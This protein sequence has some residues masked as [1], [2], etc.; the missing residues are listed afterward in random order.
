MLCYEERYGRVR[1]FMA[2]CVMRRGM[3]G[4]G[5]SWHAVL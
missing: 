4:G 1:G 3:V 2:C 5:A